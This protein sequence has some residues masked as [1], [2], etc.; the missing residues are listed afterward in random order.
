MKRARAAAMR[1]GRTS[2]SSRAASLRSV[3]LVDLR[4]LSLPSSSS[5]SSAV[6]V[7]GRSCGTAGNG[8]NR[9][10]LVSS[11]VSVG[12]SDFAPQATCVTRDVPATSKPKKQNK[13]TCLN[14]YCRLTVFAAGDVKSAVKRAAGDVE[15][16]VKRAAGDVKSVVKRAA[17]DVKSVVKRAA[18]DVKSVVKRA[19]GD[20]KSVVKRAAGDVGIHAD[21]PLGDAG[22]NLVAL[23]AV[24]VNRRYGNRN[25]RPCSYAIGF[26]RDRR[27]QHQDPSGPRHAVLERWILHLRQAF[28][29]LHRYGFFTQP[30]TPRRRASRCADARK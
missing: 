11:A 8:G 9:A 16:A 7:G 23:S 24:W 26:R 4:R 15:S 22:D 27:E 28:P 21:G 30:Q 25:V 19:A 5:T 13:P 17:G 10:T 2:S 1:R 20:V 18:G 12:P 14:A 29:P 3:P 6:G